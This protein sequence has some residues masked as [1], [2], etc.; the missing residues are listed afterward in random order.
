MRRVLGSILLATALA[1]GCGRLEEGA[2]PQESA[3][4]FRDAG[5]ETAVRRALNQPRGPLDPAALASLQRLD[6]AAVGVRSLEEIGRLPGLRSLFLGAN[7]IVDIAPLAVLDSL[8]VLD[9]SRNRVGDLG[10][11]AALLRLTH[12]NADLNAVV[13]LAPLAGLRRLQLVNVGNNRV[14]DV[15]P[16]LA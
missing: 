4:L 6:A 11:L 7:D 15:S 10:A 16:L 8:E 5:L 13:S 12:F 14:R 9:L 2:G 1:A 3:P